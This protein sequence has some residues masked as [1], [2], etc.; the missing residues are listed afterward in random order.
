MNSAKLL[1]TCLTPSEILYERK[2]E[3]PQE[4]LFPWP[5]EE[6]ESYAEFVKILTDLRLTVQKK[7]RERQLKLKPK[8]DKKR[9]WT[10]VYNLGELVLVIRDISKKGKSRIFLLH[11]HGTLSSC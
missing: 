8:I 3:L 6:S 7:L 1:S 9:K 5:G 11:F 2:A 4:S 10:R